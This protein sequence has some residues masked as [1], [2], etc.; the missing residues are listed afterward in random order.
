MNYKFT[1]KFLYSVFIFLCDYI[2]VL[3]LWTGI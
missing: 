1:E 2:R 3:E